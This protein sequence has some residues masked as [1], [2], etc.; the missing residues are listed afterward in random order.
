MLYLSH[1]LYKA[2]SGDV[3]KDIQLGNVEYL[4]SSRSTSLQLDLL[5]ATLVSP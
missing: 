2:G 3:R 1:C 5:S 4:K